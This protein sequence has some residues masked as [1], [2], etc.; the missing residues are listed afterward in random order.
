[1]S[2]LHNLQGKVKEM[3]PSSYQVTQT[4]NENW[5][6]MKQSFT[7]KLFLVFIDKSFLIFF[8]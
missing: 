1:M 5:Q 6:T 7:D 3:T 8:G 4:K 2:N